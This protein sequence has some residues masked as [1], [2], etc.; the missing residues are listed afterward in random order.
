M[1]NT[2]KQLDSQ[3]IYTGYHIYLT[4][5][6]IQLPD[7]RLSERDV[8]HHPGAVAMLP[9]MDDDT[10]LL[11]KQY[12]YAAQCALWE[13][14]AGTL[15]KDEQPLLAAYRELREE[16]GY[17]AAEMT[18]LTD[19]FSSPGFL[20]EKLH[21]FVARK[22]TLDHQDLDPDEF[23]DVQPFSKSQVQTMLKDGAFPDAKT[24]IALLYWLNNTL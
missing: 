22:L 13:I 16:T 15:E 3:L 2:E 21:L 24:Q 12:R 10:V 23:I 19:F 14:P 1:N 5:D 8:I 18:P 11:V 20:N 17:V 6:H 7:G 9:L 4:H